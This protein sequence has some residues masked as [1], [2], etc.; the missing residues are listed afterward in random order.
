[1]AD[2]SDLME[3]VV[4][5]LKSVAD[6]ETGKDIVAAGLVTELEVTDN[7]RVR[8]AM[9]SDGGEPGRLTEAA[10]RAARSVEGVA[11]VEIDMR[12]GGRG[13][14]RGG[15]KLP[16]AGQAPGGDRNRSVSGTPSPSAPPRPEGVPGVR[17]VVAISSGKGGVGKSTIA[18]NLA[19]ALAVK[20]ARVGLLDADVYGP[21]I[22]IMFGVH[23]RPRVTPDER[24]VPLEAHGVKLMSIGF[25][26]DDDTP[27]I[28]RGPIVMG[29]IRQ[30]LQQVAWGELDYLLVDMPPGTGDAQLSLVQLAKVDGALMVTT[31]QGVAVADVL[32]G[33]KMFERVD[34]PVLGLVENMS[35][36]CCPHC[37]ER[38]D[39]FGSG[40]GR[41]LAAIAGVPFLGEVPMGASVV[42]AGDSG[43][44][45]VLAMPESP[46]A[47]A[48][49][50]LAER[51]TAALPAPERAETPQH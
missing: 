16:V 29:I 45:T 17:H 34:V 37:G 38:T 21:D 23:S 14:R 13:R 19:A 44:P 2:H 24:V 26:M 6:P 32:K 18:T 41:K 25:L 33:I 11:G 5:A 8:F 40:G 42:A 35:G 15:R 49:M 10:R 51:V 28:W 50:E 43:Q 4:A 46:E 39:V 48:L 3:N 20:G 7:G 47:M 30:F 1:M 22:P 9:V 31:P 12:P 27:A 36:F